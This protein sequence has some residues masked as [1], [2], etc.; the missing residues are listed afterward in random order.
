MYLIFGGEEFYASGG[1]NDF[2]GACKNLGVANR[3]AAE[4]IGKYVVT[5]I[6]EYTDDRNCDTSHKIEWTHVVDGQNGKI[7]IKFGGRPHGERSAPLFCIEGE[8]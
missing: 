5:E 2:L 7:L 6:A 4:L 1:G 8:K 3:R